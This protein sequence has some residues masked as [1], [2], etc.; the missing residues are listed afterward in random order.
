[1]KSPDQTVKESSF[2]YTTKPNFNNHLTAENW[3]VRPEKNTDPADGTGPAFS[4]DT[5][6]TRPASRVNKKF[7]NFRIV[8]RRQQLQDANR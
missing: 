1:M 4:R 2:P 6:N 8:S 3:L 7:A 5:Q